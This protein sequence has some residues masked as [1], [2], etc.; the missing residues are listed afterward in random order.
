[1]MST[2][3]CGDCGKLF[4]RYDNLQRHR[5]TFHLVKNSNDDD[6]EDSEDGG[7]EDNY[8]PKITTKYDTLSQH[9]IKEK[10]FIAMYK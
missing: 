4:S 10:K 1:M 5:R 3:T 9:K 8:T 7:A 6:D 2:L